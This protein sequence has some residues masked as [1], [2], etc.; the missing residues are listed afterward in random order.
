LPR[1]GISRTV[2]CNSQDVLD[3]DFWNYC[4]QHVGRSGGYPVDSRDRSGVRVIGRHIRAQHNRSRL[5]S[6]F[7]WQSLAIILAG[8]LGAATFVAIGVH[9]RRH[10]RVVKGAAEKTAIADQIA[11]IIDE[12]VEEL[13][14]VCP[15]QGESGR[16]RLERNP[17][18]AVITAYVR[19]QRALEVAGMPRQPAE[20]S[21]EYLERA[22][23]P[24]L[25]ASASAVAL[26]T[27]LFEWARFS[28]HD[29]EPAMRDRAIAAL[30]AVRDEL[31]AELRP[32]PVVEQA[33]RPR[34][35]RLRLVGK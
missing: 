6:T 30:L 16:R 18:Q 11:E 20:A 1:A 13:G 21:R 4:H 14:G 19:M 34:R 28:Q 17:R 9:R 8:T 29:V 26:L 15:R 3:L 7:D 10:P 2:D 24:R 25:R 12:S 33:L 23:Q 27:S 5:G 32:A 22:L 31:R 35:R